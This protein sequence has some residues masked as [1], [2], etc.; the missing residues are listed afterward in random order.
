MFKPPAVQLPAAFSVI[1]LSETG[2]ESVYRNKNINI[3]Y[4][5]DNRIVITLDAGGTNLVFGAMRGCEYI[6]QPVTYPSN[7]HDL[8]LCLDT[9]VKGFREVMDSLEERPVA[10]SFAFPGPADYPNGII[11]GYLPNF[12]SFRDGVALGPFLQNELG[13]PVFINNDG[14]LF[15]YGEALCG[16]LPEVN[17]RLAEAGSSRRYKNMLGYTFG[18]GF[19]V[20][21]VINGHLNRGDNSCVETFC[22]PHKT[23]E[24]VIVEEGVSVRA[25]KRVYAEASDDFSHS[26]EPKDICEIADGKREGNVEAARKAFAEF[27]ETA[28]HAM[29]I[30]VQLVDGLIVIGGGITAARHHILPSLLEVLRSDYATLGGD[31]V[32]RVQMEVYNLD[33]PEE[34]EAFA[35][36]NKRSLTVRGTNLSVEYDSMKR[37]GVTFSKL[38]ASRA[39]SAGAYAFA[40]SELDKPKLD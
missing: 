16:A 19:G 23:K 9:M 3:M 28:G 24:G 18:T 4:I 39:I 21:M 34:F 12:P 11:G 38:G 5:H 29:A 15:A 31:K 30:A 36:G 8:D 6:T 20:G 27:G 26:Y 17:R 7:A 22:L 37:I 2:R 35:R 14:D 1:I 33:N 13:L 10:I 40:L 25:I 32:K